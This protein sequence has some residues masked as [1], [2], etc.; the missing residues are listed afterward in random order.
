MDS[1][2]D[3]ARGSFDLFNRLKK[4][5]FNLTWVTVTEPTCGKGE[6]E[7]SVPLVCGK[8]IGLGIMVSHQL[9]VPRASVSWRQK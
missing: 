7:V 8:A 4:F 6:H 5:I 3:G 2:A 9:M 1:I